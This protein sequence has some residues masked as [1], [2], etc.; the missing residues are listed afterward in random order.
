MK[1]KIAISVDKELLSLIDS[2]IDNITIR[3]RSQAIEILTRKGLGFETIETAIIMVKGDQQELVIKDIM[4]KQVSYLKKYGVLNIVILTQPTRTLKSFKEQIRKIDPDI[5]V[6]DVKSKGNAHGLFLI[7]DMLEHNFIVISGDVF[8]GFDLKKMTQ[9]HKRQDK[10]MTIGLM[11]V[12]NKEMNYG[13]VNLDGDIV[14]DYEEKDKVDPSS[15]VNAGTYIFKSEIFHLFDKKTKS[16]EKDI[17]PKVAKI[18][19]MA[20]F[21]ALGEYLHL[22]D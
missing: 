8:H 21:F 6:K 5:V 22:R 10:L 16:L 4:R 19:Q 20:G 3:S 17:F 12:K 7:K 1:E 15:I 14:L 9:K 13:K 11:T 18:K 2:K